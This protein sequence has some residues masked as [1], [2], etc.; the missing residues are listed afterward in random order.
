MTLFVQ[1]CAARKPEALADGHW[2]RVLRSFLGAYNREEAASRSQ[3]SYQGNYS[4]MAHDAA[5]IAELEFALGYP[6]DR[7]RFFLH[8]SAEAM[9]RCVQLRG[10]LES[11]EITTTLRPRPDGSVVEEIESAKMCVD[12]SMGTPMHAIPAVY[13]AWLARDPAL[14]AEIA[15]AVN[16]HDEDTEAYGKRGIARQMAHVA[17]LRGHEQAASKYLIGA[18]PADTRTRL[19]AGVLG[20]NQD[21]FDDALRS[22]LK[23]WERYERKE[24]R[25]LVPMFA[26]KGLK[27]PPYFYWSIECMGGALLGLK[28]GLELRIDHAFIPREMLEGC[29]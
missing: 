17:W 9:L 27:P 29:Y 12:V 21:R 14:G 19:L 1:H 15:R 7:V 13:S 28:R 11:P 16:F 8:K 4:G 10:T 24:R 23:S 26:E 18:D 6:L 3:L 5:H 2:V 20:C 22:L 25:G